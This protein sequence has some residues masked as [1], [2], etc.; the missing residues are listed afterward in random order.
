MSSRTH[1]VLRGRNIYNLEPL[2]DALNT[3]TP[4]IQERLGKVSNG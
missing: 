4:I 1:K 2:I 3:L